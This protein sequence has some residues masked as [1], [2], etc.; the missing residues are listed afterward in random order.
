MTCRLKKTTKNHE[1]VN[2]DTKPVFG[3]FDFDQ[4]LKSKSP[5]I[6]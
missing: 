6:Q 2:N 3:D 5:N 1:N 4:F